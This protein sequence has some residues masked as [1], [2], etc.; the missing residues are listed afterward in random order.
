MI[1]SAVSGSRDQR[2]DTSMRIRQTRAT[3]ASRKVTLIRPPC[4]WSSTGRAG[5]VPKDPGCSADGPVLVADAG[6]E[7]VQGGEACVQVVRR[8][9]EA[10]AQVALGLEVDAR[11]DHRRVVAD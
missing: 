10:D 2:P 5:S 3:S 6:E 11:H 4:E 1:A 7:P 8:A 9:A